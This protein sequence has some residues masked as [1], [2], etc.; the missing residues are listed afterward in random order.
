M[1]QFIGAQTVVGIAFET[2][3]GTWVAPTRFFP[4]KSESLSEPFAHVARRLIRGVADNLGHVAGNHHVEGD[5]VMELYPDLLPYFLYVSRN[6]ISKSGAGPWTYTTTPTHVGDSTALTKPSISINVFKAG[7]SFGFRGCVVSGM[8]IGVEEGIPILTVHIIGSQESDQADPTP[9]FLTTDVPVNATG[10]NIQIPDA[11]QIF[12]VEN[13][14]WSVN[15]N[16]EPQFRLGNTG[17]Q[18]VK[19]GERE[20]KA[21]A[22]RDFNSRTEFDAYKA[23]TATSFTLILTEGARSVTIKMANVTRETYEIDPSDDQGS[24]VMATINYMGNYNIA[25]SKAYEIVCIS[26]VT[27]IT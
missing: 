22:V 21:E 1:P 2:T 8:E 24:P 11:S 26:S 4:V 10:W 15:D 14:T 7:E 12:T 9:T 13:V 20:V 18:W 16:C 25:T 5:L 6:S 19:F 3:Y 17:A 27:N 23:V